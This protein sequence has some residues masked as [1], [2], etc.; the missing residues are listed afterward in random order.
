MYYIF[1][2]IV[3]NIKEKKYIF[4]GITHTPL[5]IDKIKLFCAIISKNPPEMGW[6][7]TKH[8]NTKLMLSKLLFL[9]RNRCFIHQLKQ[10]DF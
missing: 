2:L 4:Y 1:T 3:T 10:A 9:V 6:I 7:F 5:I 8:A